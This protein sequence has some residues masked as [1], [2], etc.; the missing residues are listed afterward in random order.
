[1][2]TKI[3]VSELTDI[4]LDWAVAKCQDFKM[5]DGDIFIKDGM[6]VCRVY[7]HPCEYY[8]PSTK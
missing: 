3:K 1:M 7:K 5:D 2:Y 6:V 4:V 8:S